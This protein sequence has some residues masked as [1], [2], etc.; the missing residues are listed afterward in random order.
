MGSWWAVS[1][2]QWAAGTAWGL[3][4][5]RGIAYILLLAIHLHGVIHCGEHMVS[6]NFLKN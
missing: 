2:G 4:E 3:Q 5:E 6:F 1:R